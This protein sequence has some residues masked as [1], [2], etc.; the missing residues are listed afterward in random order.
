MYADRLRVRHP[1]DSKFAL[2]PHM[3]G[4]SVERWED[5]AYRSVYAKILEGKWEEYDAYEI[6]ES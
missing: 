3:D 1:G 5:E 4:G 2:G 6:G